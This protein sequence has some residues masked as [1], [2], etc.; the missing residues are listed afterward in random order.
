MVTSNPTPEAEKGL[1]LTPQLPPKST[2]D[3]N[4]LHSDIKVTEEF[5][6]RDCIFSFSVFLC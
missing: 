1:D 3:G 6:F 4:K 5:I 2:S